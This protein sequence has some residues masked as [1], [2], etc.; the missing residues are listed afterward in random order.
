MRMQGLRDLLL[1]LGTVRCPDRR[2]EETGRQQAAYRAVHVRVTERAGHPARTVR[3]EP[4]PRGDLLQVVPQGRP[5]AA[6]GAR[7]TRRLGEPRRDPQHGRGGAALRRSPAC[8]HHRGS[9]HRQRHGGRQRGREPLG[10]PGRTADRLERGQQVVR[11]LPVGGGCRNTVQEPRPVL[12][13]PGAGL[14]PRVGGEALTGQR[15]ALAVGV[16]AGDACP[17]RGRDQQGEPGT[18]AEGEHPRTGPDLEALVHRLVQRCQ[19]ALLDLGPVTGA[20]TGVHGGGRIRV[21]VVPD[22]RRCHG[23]RPNPP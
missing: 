7:R 18:A 2:V 12:H 1:H 16:D 3:L 11:G 22:E 4:G 15:E 5:P 13:G 8:Q 21:P 14:A 9:A 17:A 19:H 23:M 6:P 10:V 20:G